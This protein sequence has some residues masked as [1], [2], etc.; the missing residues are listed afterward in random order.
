[1]FVNIDVHS[2]RSHPVDHVIEIIRQPHTIG[3][4]EPQ[5]ECIVEKLVDLGDDRV[6]IMFKVDDAGKSS[7]PV[8]RKWAAHA[9]AVS[10]SSRSSSAKFVFWPGPKNRAKAAPHSCL[11]NRQG[12]QL[13]GGGLSPG[14]NTSANA[15]EHYFLARMVRIAE[16][17]EGQSTVR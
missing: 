3:D 12:N 14:Y 11:S 7:P 13:E 9:T 8:R 10:A 16:Y 6:T 1:L 17:Q 5:D 15:S 2:H 4:I